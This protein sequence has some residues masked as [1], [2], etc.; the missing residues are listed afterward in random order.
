MNIP[1]NSIRPGQNDDANKL[2]EA[3]MLKQLKDQGFSGLK[4]HKSL[5]G[6]RASTYNSQTEE[7]IDALI[8]F[9]E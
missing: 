5:G 3:E 8:Q 7:S 4:G 9:L 6:L 2:I 1:F